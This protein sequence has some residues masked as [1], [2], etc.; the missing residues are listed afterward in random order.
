MRRSWWGLRTR[1]A[2]GP[3][4]EGFRRG[5]VRAARRIAA[6]VSA[7]RA[8]WARTSAWCWC[9]G[10]RT[11]GSGHIPQRSRISA[12]GGIPKVCVSRP[13]PGR[14]RCGAISPSMLC[15]SIPSAGEVLDFTGGRADLEAGLIRAIGD[16]E[17][18]FRRGPSAAAARG[19][20]RGAAG[21]CR[22]SR[23]HSRAMQRLAPLIHS[24]S[25]E[26]VR[27]EIARILTEGG[28]RRGFELLDATGLAA[29]D[30]ARSRGMKGV[31][32]PPEFHPE[33]D[34]WMHTL[35]MLEGLREPSLDTGAGRSAAR[36]GQ[37][38]DVPGRGPDPLRRACGEGRRNRARDSDAVAFSER[39]DRSR[40]RR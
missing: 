7:A 39:C 17:R 29:R 20:L 9:G 26:R 3:R 23:R 18:R 15:C 2:A 13:I 27:D 35:M 30:S 31:E 10:R 38:G 22:S 12:T 14:M 21:I 40:P 1:S 36:R 19:S 5:D 24:V 37:A 4:A 34:V 25:A 28:A 8:R 32:Q 16:P 33:G 6:A 11:G